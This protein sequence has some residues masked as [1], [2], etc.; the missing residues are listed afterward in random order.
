MAASIFIASI[1]ATVSPAFTLSPTATAMVTTPWNGA[2]I[3]PGTDGSAFSAAAAS[4]STERSRTGIGRIW[5]LIVHMTV[6]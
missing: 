4:A 2:A 6:R 1:V 3:W 5:P